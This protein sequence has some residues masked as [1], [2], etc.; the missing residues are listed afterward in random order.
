MEDLSHTLTLHTEKKQWWESAFSTPH[1]TCLFTSFF[2]SLR[3][4]SSTPSRTSRHPR[5]VGEKHNA[6]LKKSTKKVE[7]RRWLEDVVISPRPPCS[8]RV[9]ESI[10]GGKED[11]SFPPNKAI[12]FSCTSPVDCLR[13]GTCYSLVLV[14]WVHPEHLA[15]C[16][17]DVLFLQR[18]L[19]LCSM[20][21]FVIYYVW[22][23]FYS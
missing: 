19:F 13:K 20:C 18:S 8:R 6:Y 7:S 17:T 15:I 14:V 16:W 9:R 10:G 4:G 12:S 23:L 3:L 21:I 2:L 11:V 5:R 22:I 1:A